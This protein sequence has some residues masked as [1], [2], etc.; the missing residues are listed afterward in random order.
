MARDGNLLERR[1]L[2]FK[3]LADP[4]NASNGLGGTSNGLIGSSG[5]KGSSLPGTDAGMTELPE[6]SGSKNK[7]NNGV[8]D[9][10][11]GEGRDGAGNGKGKGRK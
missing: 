2:G 7:T 11:I 3:W 8:R 4:M 10:G 6:T 1:I 9:H 5:D